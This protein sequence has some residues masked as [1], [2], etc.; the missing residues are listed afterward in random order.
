[1]L[2]ICSLITLLLVS[3]QLAVALLFAASYGWANGVQTIVRGT[4]PAELFGRT[5]YGHL[6]GRLAAPSFIARAAA[7]VGLTLSASPGLRFDMSVPLLILAAV[8]A[9]VTYVISIRSMPKPISG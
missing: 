3:G 2:L 6:M 5:G 8:L 4:V 9:L 7:P 1:M